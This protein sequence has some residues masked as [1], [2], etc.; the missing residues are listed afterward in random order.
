MST[1]APGLASAWGW[2]GADAVRRLE[3]RLEAALRRARTTGTPALVSVT[4]GVDSS[5]DPSAVAVASRRPG[6]PWFCLEQPDR[7]R[8]AMAAIG[9]VRALEARG[10][11][12]FGH[13]GGRWSAVAAN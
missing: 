6:E 3:A 12:R 9:C 8:C 2:L 11:G 4:A 7:D 1:R 10:A 13:V 5:V